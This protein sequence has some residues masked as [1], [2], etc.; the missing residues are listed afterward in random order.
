MRKIF[1]KIFRYKLTSIFFIIGQLIIYITIFG[2]L[3]VYNRAYDKEKDRINAVY[4]NRIELEINMSK[5][6]DFM[7][8]FA[9]STNTG[10]AV[11]SGKLAL[12][13]LE[14]GTSVRSELII[15][16][17]ELMNFKLES[18]RLPG[19]NAKNGRLEVAVGRN[20]AK[21]ATVENG[22][23]YLVIEGDRY[24]ISGILGSDKSD[25][26]D[27]KVVLNIACLGDKTLNSLM[28]KMSYTVELGSNS[29]EL[30]D[31]YKTVYGNIKSIDQDSVIKAKKL[32]SNGESTLE[33]SMAKENMQVNV[34]TYIFC[35][36]NSM[37]ISEF[38]IIQ[39]RKEF[40]IK[41]V[42]YLKE[43]VE[44]W[45]KASGLGFCLYGETSQKVCKTFE[46]I[47]KERF[48]VIKN[49]TDKEK[50]TS[51]YHASEDEKIDYKEKLA[52]ESVFQ[53]LSL[54]GV[55]SQ[56]PSE[57]IGE[58]SDKEEFIKFAQTTWIEEI[59]NDNLG[60]LL[61]NEWTKTLKMDAIFKQVKNKYDLLYKN[62]NIEKTASTNKIIVAILAILLI[63]NIISIFK[64]F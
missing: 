51:S 15:L 22:K 19:E 12:G 2:A 60:S 63:M 30:D 45:K 25:Y 29:Y 23:K 50:Y 13:I 26:W 28:K 59:T 52:F 6:V 61:Q 62:L 16:S 3:A 40:A 24:E 57:Y 39:R 64:I 47:D 27:N 11:I 54:G 1:R 21:F 4:K 42:K 34:I 9:D 31:T 55:V 14:L 8:F 58:L 33:K 46:R 18:G 56:I 32:I 10:N 53:K 43:T 7:S 36:L 44:K 5:K 49:V 20:K 37:I 38:W 35:V 41:I 17:Y 48:G